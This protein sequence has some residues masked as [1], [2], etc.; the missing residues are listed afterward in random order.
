[1]KKEK[2]PKGTFSCKETLYSGWLKTGGSSLTSRMVI[3]ISAIELVLGSWLLDIPLTN[4]E[5]RTLSISTPPDDGP[6]VSL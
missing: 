1:M 4:S 2:L 6:S 3:V 5:A